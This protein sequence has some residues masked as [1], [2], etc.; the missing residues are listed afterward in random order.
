MFSLK[1]ILSKA[2][3][4]ALGVWK[5]AI[6]RWR[7]FSPGFR[8]ALVYFLCVLCI[9]SLVWWQFNP[10]HSLV[11]D[12]DENANDI[13]DNL[14]DLNPDQESTDPP[15]T[16]G[17]WAAFEAGHDELGWP[18]NGEILGTMDREFEVFAGYY[19]GGRDGI[20]IGGTCGDV[21]LAAWQG[22]VTDVDVIGTDSF[23][24]TLTHGDWKTVYINLSDL[25]V[26]EGDSISKGQ[27]LGYLA[28]KEK[29]LYTEDYLEFQVWGPDN[30]VHDPL[31]Y[32]ER[33]R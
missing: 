27:R 32:I 14:V 22:V 26:K 1:N 20:H 23:Q 4:K 17:E 8:Y 10:G 18:L 30:E 15:E 33:N 5:K 31:Q 6:T 25:D 12:P 28:R 24:V 2:A 21:V 11:F 16:Q 3:T 9:A 29:G 19:Q 13:P 7:T